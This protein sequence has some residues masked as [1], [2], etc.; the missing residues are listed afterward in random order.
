MS[1]VLINYAHFLGLAG[2]FAALT[3]ELALFSPR[4][5]GEVARRLARI[6]A[7]YGLSA[8]VALGTGLL[9]VFDGDKPAAY[10][11]ANPLFHVKVTLFVVV[12]LLSVYPTVQFI[13][14]RRAAADAEV[15]YPSSI[16]VLLRIQL[17]LL[18]AM[19]LLA[20]LMA[21]GYGY[22]G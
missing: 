3:V 5:G 15:V 16:G 13:R 6:D 2:L 18:L 22:G 20:V 21:R 1:L 14:R 12:L 11:G 4:V 10:Y 8:L 17:A 9:K 19:P 7:L